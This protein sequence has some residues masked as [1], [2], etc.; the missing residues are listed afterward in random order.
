MYRRRLKIFL[1]GVDLAAGGFSKA[2]TFFEV[3]FPVN[4]V[5]AHLYLAVF[6]PFFLFLDFFFRV[7]SFGLEF[8]VCFQY[9]IHFQFGFKKLLELKRVH[10]QKLKRLDHLK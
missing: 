3:F 5:F 9:R 10:L 8:L 7:F 6:V 1:V 4:L 2:E